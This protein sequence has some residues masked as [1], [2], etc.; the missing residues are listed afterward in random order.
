MTRIEYDPE[1]DALYITLKRN[2]KVH[3]T[4]IARF[5]VNI[6]VDANGNPVG[7][8]VLCAVR[9]PGRDARKLLEK[10]LRSESRMVAKDSLGVLGEF[11]RLE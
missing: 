5:G 8:E 1:A 9:R 7:I 4:F 3:D 2:A 11:E 10:A 6:N